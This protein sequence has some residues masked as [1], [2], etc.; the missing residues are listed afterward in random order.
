LSVCLLLRDIGHAGGADA[1]RY[2]TWRDYGGSP[3]PM[4]YSALE[5]INRTTVKQLAPEWFYPVQG[6]AT[7]LP[8][9]PLIVDDVM[10]VSGPGDA[11][12]ALDAASGR[13]RWTSRKKLPSAGSRIGK[14]RTA[15]IAD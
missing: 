8:F 15:R 14:A 9:N 13:E 7:R 2:T 5:Q 10:Y 6:E 1:S 3:D 11:V 12:V 4:Q